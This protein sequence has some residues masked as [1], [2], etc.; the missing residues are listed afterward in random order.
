MLSI[1][2]D[3]TRLQMCVEFAVQDKL[4]LLLNTYRVPCAAC[5]CCIAAGR[6]SDCLSKNLILPDRT[7]QAMPATKAA[8]M[9]FGATGALARVKCDIRIFTALRR[10]NES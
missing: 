2:S 9:S 5:F 6:W 8:K 1:L 10:L 3:M 4:L 7:I